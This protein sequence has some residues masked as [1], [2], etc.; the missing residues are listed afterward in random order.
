M[1]E[2]ASVQATFFFISDTTF[3]AAE[4]GDKGIQRDWPPDRFAR[5]DMGGVKAFVRC[6]ARLLRWPIYA[7]QWRDRRPGMAS[8]P[9]IAQDMLYRRLRRSS[10]P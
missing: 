2:C 1:M 8:S 10:S 6:I 5:A 4:P 9:D 3:H 7:R